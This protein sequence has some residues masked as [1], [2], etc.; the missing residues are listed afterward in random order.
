M[1][2]REAALAL[3]ADGYSP[4]RDSALE[5]FYTCFAERPL[6]ID[7][8]FAIQARATRSDTAEQVERL[9]MRTDFNLANPNRARSLIENFGQNQRAFHSADGKG[10]RWLARQTLAFDAINPRTAAKFLA[11]LAGW[12]KLEANRAGL[13]QTELQA[14][15]ATPGISKDLLELVQK[16]VVSG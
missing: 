9:S 3:L 6:V 2:D 10:Y 11:P 12:R 1:T 7:K 5:I 8:W 15:A 14:I 4:L 13:M 16:S